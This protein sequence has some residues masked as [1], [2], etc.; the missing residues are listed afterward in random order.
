MLIVY[1]CLFPSQNIAID[2]RNLRTMNHIEKN[3]NSVYYLNALDAAV[4]ADHG[5]L[6]VFVPEVELGEVAQ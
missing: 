2:T 3:R 4:G 1:N 6:D 5:V